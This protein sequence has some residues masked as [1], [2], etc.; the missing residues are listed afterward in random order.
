MYGVYR[1]VRGWHIHKLLKYPVRD[2]DI[3]SL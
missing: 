1:I 3:V 2:K